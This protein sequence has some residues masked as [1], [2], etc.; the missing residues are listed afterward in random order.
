[1]Q[2]AL[3]RDRHS[4]PGRCAY[5]DALPVLDGEPDEAPIHLCRLGYL[6][7]AE[8]WQFAFYKYSGDSY[9]PSCLPSGSFTG[10]PEEAFDCAAFTYPS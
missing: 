5:V 6:G 9:E 10:S 7:Q 8:R 3:P 2:W 4:L 1:M